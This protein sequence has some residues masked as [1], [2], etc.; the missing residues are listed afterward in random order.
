[1][2]ATS[3]QKRKGYLVIGAGGLILSAG[4]L[5]MAVQLPFGEIA[6]PGASVFPIM[7]GVMLALTSLATVW[8]GW[9][10]NIGEQVE[11]PAGQDRKRLLTLI[12]ALFL[13]ILVLPWLGQ[14]LASTLF[15]ILL[16]RV[17]SEVGWPR[18]IAYSLVIS[19]SLYVVFVR[20][21]KVPMP[22]GIVDF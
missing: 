4:Y 12:G 17:L 3:L 1:M 2:Q 22:R 19:I 9:R 21:L 16:M 10:T 7:V 5:G 15:L 13:Y 20:L 14:I 11:F 18:V 8:E 6:R